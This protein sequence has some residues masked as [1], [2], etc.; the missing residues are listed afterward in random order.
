MFL[1]AFK[2]MDLF[3]ATMINYLQWFQLCPHF[4]QRDTPS[5]TDDDLD[6]LPMALGWA[7]C[8]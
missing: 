6:H 1:G 8:M 7:T 3:V 5:D 2:K 4:G